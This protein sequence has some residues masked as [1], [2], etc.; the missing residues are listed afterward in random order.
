MWSINRVLFC[1]VYRQW[2]LLIRLKCVA[3]LPLIPYPLS[4]SFFPSTFACPLPTPT[5]YLPLYPYPFPTPLPLLHLC[6]LFNW[7]PYASSL[8][9]LWKCVLAFTW[10]SISFQSASMFFC[11]EAAKRLL[12]RMTSNDSTLLCP[13]PR[14]QVFKPATDITPCQLLKSAGAPT[15]RHICTHNR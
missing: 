10:T 5:Q 7:S 13:T 9:N 3:K 11:F 1:E 15:G 4:S 12:S 2:K 14:V 8:Q 6:I